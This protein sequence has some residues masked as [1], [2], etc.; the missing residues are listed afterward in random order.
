MNN[1]I[2]V[3]I[4]FSFV[5]I[6]I[7]F[8]VKPWESQFVENKVEITFDNGLQIFVDIADIKPSRKRGLM[9]REKMESNEGMLFVFDTEDYYSFWMRNMKFPVDM[10]WI[11]MDNRVIHIEEDVPVCVGEA[12]EFYPPLKPAKYMLEINAGVASHGRIKIGDR[13]TVSS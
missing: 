7:L 4:I 10:I 6:S 13:I 11:D 12:C 8:F 9:Y 1:R 3:A 2:K 5:I